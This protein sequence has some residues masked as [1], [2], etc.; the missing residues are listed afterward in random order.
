[1]ETTAHPLASPPRPETVARWIVRA[2]LVAWG[3][4]WVW[5]NVASGLSEAGIPGALVGHSVFA[6]VIVAAVVVAWRWERIGG[7][8][9]LALAV[10]IQLYIGPSGA[11]VAM[12]TLPPAATGAALVA[13][14][15]PSRRGRPPLRR[16]D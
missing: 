11:T 4:F 9:L 16:R 8:L 15:L 5:F 6:A 13:L 14:S 7:L 3:A 12:I 10:A 1:M 2:V